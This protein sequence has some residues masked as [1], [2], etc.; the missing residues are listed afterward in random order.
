MMEKEWRKNEGE[1]ERKN[2]KM[3]NPVTSLMCSYTIVMQIRTIV[4]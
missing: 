1:K 3:K 2:I 4:F